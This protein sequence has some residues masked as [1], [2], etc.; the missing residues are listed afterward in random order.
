MISYI[1]SNVSQKI[2]AAQILHK[3]FMPN[4]SNQKYACKSR[5]PIQTSFENIDATDSIGNN[6]WPYQMCV[7]SFC[8]EKFHACCRN[9]AQSWIF[10]QIGPNLGQIW[11]AYNCTKI[12]RKLKERP[13]MDSGDQGLSVDANIFVLFFLDPLWYQL[14]MRSS[15]STLF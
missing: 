6:N 11:C 5:K 1:F 10:S 14:V 9:W 2:E 15:T 8:F 3:E 7:D 4:F 12:A 13:E